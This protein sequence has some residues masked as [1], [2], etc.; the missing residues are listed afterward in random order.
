MDGGLNTYTYVNNSPIINYDLFGLITWTGTQT[1]VAAGEG[2]GAVRFEFN[3]ESD[4]V[5]GKKAKVEI[6]AGGTMLTAGAPISLTHSR[7][8]EFTDSRTRLDPMVFHGEAKYAYASYALLPA[9]ASYQW[10]KL[11]DAESIGG[12]FQQGWDAS[13]AVGAGISTVTKIEIVECCEK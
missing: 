3:L 11:G 8:V 9:G 1:T 5:D 7:G 4:C 10:I 12:G 13:I 2:G 6:V